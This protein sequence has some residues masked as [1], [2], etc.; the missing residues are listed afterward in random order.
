MK[1]AVFISTVYFLVG[2]LGILVPGNDKNL[3]TNYAKMLGK[4]L[5][6]IVRESTNIVLKM[7]DISLSLT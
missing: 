6:L 5:P 3:V 4:A 1:L 7:I 2:N